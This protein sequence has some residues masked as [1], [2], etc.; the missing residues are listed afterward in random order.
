[1]AERRSNNIAAARENNL[2]DEV[3]VGG[4]DQGIM[5]FV[6]NVFSRKKPEPVQAVPTS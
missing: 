3:S 5:S 6:D 1:M 4:G 2:F